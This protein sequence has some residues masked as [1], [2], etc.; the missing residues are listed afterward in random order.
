[1][2]CDAIFIMGDGLTKIP[3]ALKLAWLHVVLFE[4]LHVIYFGYQF[5]L[6]M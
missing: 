3:S 5:L 2:F 1:M 4:F 6:R